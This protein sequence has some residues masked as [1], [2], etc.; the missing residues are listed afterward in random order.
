MI[1]VTKVIN[2]NV[3]NFNYI[4]NNIIYDAH[5]SFLVAVVKMTNSLVLKNKIITNNNFILQYA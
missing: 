5:L 4:S 2:T 3:Q 1:L